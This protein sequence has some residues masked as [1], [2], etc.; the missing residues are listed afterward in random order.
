METTLYRVL[1]EA[2]TNVARHAEAGRVG[3]I[4][5]ASEQEARLIVEDDGHG[6]TWDDSGSGA[7]SGRLGLLGMRER[8]TLVGGTLE[9][10][11]SP[12]GGTTLFSRVPLPP[13]ACE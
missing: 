1:Q 12:G 3:I 6:F 5:E 13:A 2:V 7:P 8:L 9:V 10:E 11:T 4:L